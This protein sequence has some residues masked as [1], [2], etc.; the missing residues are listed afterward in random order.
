MLSHTNRQSRNFIPFVIER[1]EAA[2]SEM[3]E[4]KK[5]K[6]L[7]VQKE[8]DEQKNKLDRAQ[9][10]NS[11]LAREVRSAAGVKSELPEEVRRFKTLLEKST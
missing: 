2:Y 5:N 3:L 1:D 10:Q 8:L 4:E 7:Q 11:K 9:R 6:M